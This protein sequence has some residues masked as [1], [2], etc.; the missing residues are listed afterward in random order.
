M[1]TGV[2]GVRDLRGLLERTATARRR[3]VTALEAARGG[4]LLLAAWLA[5][6]LL[7]NLV[8]LP[9]VLRIALL[10]ALVPGGLWFVGRR[11]AAAAGRRA[12]R[13]EAARLLATRGQLPRNPLL[14]AV[15]FD[16]ALA[17]GDPSICPEFA[18]QVLDEAR[19]A[20]ARLDTDAVRDHDRLRK[21][22]MALAGAA[23]AAAAYGL[24]LPS[25]AS[26]ALA[27]FANP[28]SESVV[29][30][31]LAIEVAP[32]SARL[33]AGQVLSVRATISARGT[34]ALPD[35]ATL[36]IEATD[37]A[38]RRLPMLGV[39]DSLIVSITA[40]GLL[41]EARRQRGDPAAWAP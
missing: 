7:D 21:A 26:G 34:T 25:L 12:N 20:S 4:A 24:L 18:E 28:L 10:L 35:E 30:T 14:D 41:Y 40:S 38:S 37:G 17:R 29:E 33:S 19:R 27:R 9:S 11:V 23:V 15:L 22:G 8:S 6:C 32:G 31:G 5:A 1:K 16:E 13:A 36:E 2:S 3:A 39:A